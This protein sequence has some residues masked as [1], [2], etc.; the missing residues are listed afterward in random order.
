MKDGSTVD[1]QVDLPAQ[2]SGHSYKCSSIWVEVAAS[3]TGKQPV[4]EM[5][6]ILYRV[7]TQ[8]TSTGIAN[9]LEEVAVTSPR[10]LSIGTRILRGAWPRIIDWSQEQ[11]DAGH[12]ETVATIRMRNNSGVDA[13]VTMVG[14]LTWRERTRSSLGP[15]DERTVALCSHMAGLDLHPRLPTVDRSQKRERMSAL[16]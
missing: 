3:A 8:S 12:P 4:L 13:E 6:L 7:Q 2:A 1:Y 11:T 14:C 10:M 9:N 15:D 5:L 16:H